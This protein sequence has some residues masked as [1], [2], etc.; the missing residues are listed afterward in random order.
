MLSKR[1][2]RRV[3]NFFSSR[4]DICG[5]ERLRWFIEIDIKFCFALK[6]RCRDYVQ[7]I[8]M[9]M[10]LHCRVSLLYLYI[11]IYMTCGIN[12]L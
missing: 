5:H 1:L 6:M 7:D 9:M 12:E 8:Y 10:E 3:A 2:L 11:Y 4:S